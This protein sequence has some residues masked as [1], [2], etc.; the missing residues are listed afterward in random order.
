MLAE[1]FLE[2]GNAAIAGEPNAE[3]RAACERLKER[4][5]KLSVVGAAAEATTLGCC[6]GLRGGGASVALV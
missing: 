5:P 2:N 4:Y 3:M 6:G 1:L